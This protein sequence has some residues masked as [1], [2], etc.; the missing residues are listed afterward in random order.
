M[1]LYL[2]LSLWLNKSLFLLFLYFY[3]NYTL[4]L[5]LTENDYWT[6]KMTTSRELLTSSLSLKVSAMIHQMQTQLR[7]NH[8]PRWIKSQPL[9][10]VI[11]GNF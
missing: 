2:F 4:C 7:P 9:N 5:L 8:F 11:M 10:K 1:F 6:C 3:N